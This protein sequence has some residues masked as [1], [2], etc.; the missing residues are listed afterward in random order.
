MNHSQSSKTENSKNYQ[1]MPSYLL[2]IS[3][4][5]HSIKK[6]MHEYGILNTSYDQWKNRR[7]QQYSFL[8]LNEVFRGPLFLFV[9]V[10]IYLN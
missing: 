7:F 4:N 8:I 1:F 9:A 2:R 10:L 3:L 6:E 5:P